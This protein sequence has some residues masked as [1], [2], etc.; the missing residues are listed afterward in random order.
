[1]DNGDGRAP[2]QE[3]SCKELV[4]LVTDYL[5]GWLPAG[6]RRRFEAH[7]GGCP[8]CATYVEQIRET[9]RLTGRLREDDLAAPVRDSLL[10]AFRDWK[11]GSPG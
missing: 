11:R 9:I 1:M 3:M 6:E 8:G 4:E 7:L 10:A 5:E 2:A